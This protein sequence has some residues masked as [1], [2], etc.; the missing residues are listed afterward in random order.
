M[1]DFGKKPTGVL[2]PM[3]Y[4]GM[5]VITVL[6]GATVFDPASGQSEIVRDNMTVVLND[7]TVYMTDK[8][9]RRL[10]IL[11]AK[12]KGKIEI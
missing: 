12:A 9:Y 7:K 4:K 3:P 5:D 2:M 1:T 11:A 8:N 10:K 6:E